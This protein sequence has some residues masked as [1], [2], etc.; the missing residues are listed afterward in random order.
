MQL[1]LLGVNAPGWMSFSGSRRSGV[2]RQLPNDH[3]DHRVM[4]GV[5]LDLI[6]DVRLL[7]ESDPLES[8]EFAHGLQ[9]SPGLVRALSARRM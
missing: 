8:F 1:K 9:C 6:A 5:D 7:H 4:T 3:K 2:P